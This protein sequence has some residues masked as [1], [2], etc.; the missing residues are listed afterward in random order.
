MKM[1]E[2]NRECKTIDHSG[3]LG[4]NSWVTFDKFMLSLVMNRKSVC[5]PVLSV[6]IIVQTEDLNFLFLIKPY[7]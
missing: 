3:I 7:R 1:H 2:E 4:S 5:I 6:Q